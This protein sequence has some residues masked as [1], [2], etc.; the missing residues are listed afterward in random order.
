M[1]AR[2]GIFVLVCGLATALLTGCSSSTTTTPPP[3]PTARIRVIHASTDFGAVD[4][5]LGDESAPRAAGVEYL[6]ASVF[7]SFDTPA[8]I[9][10]VFRRAGDPATATPLFIGQDLEVSS[11]SSISAVACGLLASSD[12]ADKLRL[13]PLQDSWLAHDSGE[14]RVRVVNAS[15]D[16]GEVTVT[17][18]GG[19]ILADNL[20]RFADSGLGGESYPA[21]ADLDANV[22]EGSG[23]MS[24]A[25][26]ALDENGD[27]YYVITG[28]T[29]S[30]GA[31]EFTLMTVGPGGSVDLRTP[32][33]LESPT[34]VVHSTPD[35]GDVDVYLFQGIGAGQTRSAI[36]MALSYGGSSVRGGIDGRAAIIRMYDAGDDPDTDPEIYG[37]SID[38]PVTTEGVTVFA[39]GLRN[40][41]DIADKLR[42]MDLVDVFA[43][44]P[45]GQLPVRYIH[46]SPGAGTLLIDVNADGPE[47]AIL[48]L[49]EVSESMT[50][51][52]T[53]GVLIDVRVQGTGSSIG[54]FTTPTYA[55]G[56]G[57]YL[58]FTGIVNGA[59]NFALLSLSPSAVVDLTDP[60]GS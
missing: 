30:T 18:A 59:P 21:A 17:I 40:S 28:L 1:S 36:H 58:V 23:V 26:P 8:T 27:F 7:F 46:G 14:S 39:L 15:A 60:A 9:F 53:T 38:L 24:F 47:E 25:A 34:R 41:S 48:D 29:G 37:Q 50:L 13:L 52:A 49:F 11:G 6:D 45:A 32:T 57:H 51:P 54:L 3:Q 56:E 12:D 10:L 43:S 20:A 2:L 55:E 16:A 44:A 22:F 19:A 33:W 35:M 5:Y 31:D 42:L 4:I